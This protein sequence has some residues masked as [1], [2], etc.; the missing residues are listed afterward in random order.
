M[1]RR[2]LRP[3]V[4]VQASCGSFLVGLSP[5]QVEQLDT[6]ILGVDPHRS[7]DDQLRGAWL[8]EIIQTAIRGFE[9]RLEKP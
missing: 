1:G 3:L 4:E 5:R 8:H 2:L 9:Q 7:V 6:T